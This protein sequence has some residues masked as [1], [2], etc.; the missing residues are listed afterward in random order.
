MARNAHARGFV[1]IVVISM[2]MAMTVL[3]LGLMHRSRQ[4]L[5]VSD[6][7]LRA[8]Q[9]LACAQS[10]LQTGLE[11]I[12][13][14][15]DPS[16][17]NQV[18]DFIGRAHHFAFDYGHGTLTLSD[19][20][21]KFNVN[22]LIGGAD[23]PDRQRIDQMLAL[24][25]VLNRQS[26][27]PALGYGLVPALID[28][29]DKD[30]ETTHL[31]FIAQENRGAESDVY[32][33]ATTLAGCANRPL[34][35]PADLYLLH[36]VSREAVDRLLPFVTAWGSGLI[37][38]N[39]APAQVL[40][41]LTEDLDTTLAELIVEQRQRRPFEDLQELE[42]VPGMSVTILQKLQPSICFAAE[43]PTFRI[44]AVGQVGGLK[45]TVLAWA[46]K[47]DTTQTVD[48]IHYQEL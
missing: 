18:R 23:K 30:S 26:A 10:T 28:W 2:I 36:N 7:V 16:L 43:K 45:R 1:L 47:N 35:H 13:R 24:I 33:S 40:E 4:A 29:T 42:R 37:N 41:A 20:S 25:D 14:V 6:A 11:V 22:R 38:I 3:V 17:D 46:K 32:N 12:A 48:V 19:E 27:T 39:S 5:R 44:E 8:A 34:S 15:E 31:E 21:G 9:A